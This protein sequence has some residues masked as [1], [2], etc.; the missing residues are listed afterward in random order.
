MKLFEFESDERELFEFVLIFWSRIR[1]KAGVPLLYLH[2]N[3]PT[4]EK[5]SGK[6]LSGRYFRNENVDQKLL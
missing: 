1:L 3:C 6:K 5:P 2:G 4:L